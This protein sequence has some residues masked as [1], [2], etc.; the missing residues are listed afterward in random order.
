MSDKTGS[1]LCGA[2]AFEITGQLRRLRG[3]FSTARDPEQAIHR[4]QC[5][6]EL[7]GGLPATSDNHDRS[8][9]MF[10]QLGNL[11][12]RHLP[13]TVR[14]ISDMRNGTTADCES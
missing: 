13:W 14:M 1:C 5:I 4:T 11:V 7:L 12:A 8:R 3:S 10:V 2:V 6:S 9:D